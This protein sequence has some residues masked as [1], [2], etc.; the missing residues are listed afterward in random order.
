MKQDGVVRLNPEHPV[1]LVGKI[2]KRPTELRVPLI[3]RR[4]LVGL[5]D[6]AGSL[7][8][9]LERRDEFAV[10]EFQREHALLQVGYNRVEGVDELF[11]VGDALFQLLSGGVGFL[12]HGQSV[13]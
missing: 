3:V 8:L 1:N 10:L 9:L 7:L 6:G 5:S 2:S 13:T 4:R 12:I 11:A